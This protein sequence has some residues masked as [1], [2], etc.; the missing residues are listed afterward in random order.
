MTVTALPL[1]EHPAFAVLAAVESALDGGDL[2]VFEGLSG[3]DA[4]QV[5]A[6]WA[7][8]QARVSAHSVAAARAVERS[9]AATK[10]GATSTGSLMAGQF[11]GDRPAAARDVH[12]GEDLAK[13]STTETALAKGQVTKEQARLI[14]RTVT[15]LPETV[16]DETREKCERALIEDA[17]TLTMPDLRRRADRITDVFKP[18]SEVDADEGEIVRDRERDAYARSEFWMQDQADG[19][20][21]GH[22]RLPEAQAGML[23]HALDRFTAPRRRHLD[24]GQAAEDLTYSQRQGRAFV[25]LVEHLPTGGLPDAGGSGLVV[26]VN[27]DLDTLVEGV[28]V[29]MTSTGQRMSAGEV[30]RAACR[31]GV[32]PQVLGG[33]SLPLDLGRTQRLFNRAQRL[34]LA[35]RD[36]GCAFPDCDRSPS[37]TEAHH[38]REPWSHGGAT[39]L[40]DG[41]LLCPF[42]HRTVHDDGW[43]ITFDTPDR[44]PAF[45]PPARLDPYV[46]PRT[47]TRYRPRQDVVRTQV[48]RPTVE[49]GVRAPGTAPVQGPPPSTTDADGRVRR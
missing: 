29:G 49:A 26:T 3:D 36:G 6:R 14:A 4:T 38:A 48:V 32:I 25:A 8:V 37:W 43:T 27:V 45:V 30:R 47:S 42:H 16:P 28:G 15:S 5:A 34:A 35:H 46:R 41:V 10:A 22:F 9:G 24:H 7:R 44:R 23:K 13:A 31:A 21:V 39:D 1:T 19:T 20:W 2:S 33:A 17:Q 40:D 12:L 18:A 11:G